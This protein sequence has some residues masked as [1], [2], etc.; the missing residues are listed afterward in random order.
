MIMTTTLR[1][2]DNAREI[3]H[4]LVAL[5]CRYPQDIEIQ[6]KTLGRQTTFM[7]DV[8]RADLKLCIGKSG[9]HSKPLD[10]L[11]QMVGMNHGITLRTRFVDAP[12]RG[13][14]EPDEKFQMR[15]Q[16]DSWPVKESIETLCR[17]V[18]RYPSK[19]DVLD[20]EDGE[21]VV[22]VTTD[23]RVS[24]E[25]RRV[26]LEALTPLVRAVGLRN[27]RLLSITI[28][29][30]ELGFTGVADPLDVSN[31]LRHSKVA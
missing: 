10:R 28:A 25:Q 1:P 19:V 2:L 9:A 20:G 4:R 23:P 18:F 27:G 14:E 21:S 3:A 30:G 15:D 17:G 11:I 13:V 6:D 22:E 29:A 8:N 7:I 31:F 24:E 16:W 26:V 5:L 12:S